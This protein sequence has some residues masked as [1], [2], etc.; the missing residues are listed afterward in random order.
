MNI[1]KCI[2]LI[3]VIF[4]ILTCSNDE[5]VKLLNTSISTGN[6]LSQYY[7]K[8][9]NYTIDTWE[10]EAFNSSIREIE[11]SADEQKEYQKTI[12][13]LES[14]KRL[15]DSF[16]KILPLLKD[17]AENKSSDNLKVAVSELGNDI[18]DIKPL[19]DNKI[20]IPSDIFGNLS[21]DI[22]DIYKYYEL[23]SISKGLVKVLEKIRLLYEKESS[24]YA[25]IIEERNNKRMACRMIFGIIIEIG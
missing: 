10:L 4:L 5:T 14:R 13:S 22:M 16:V 3:P 20:I 15:V 21:Q 19:K 8:L 9:I 1:K 11:F 12:D 2:Y 7:D 17:L 6:F 18:N 23:R 25:S 24:L